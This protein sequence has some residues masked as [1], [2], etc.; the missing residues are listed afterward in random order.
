M[1]TMKTFLLFKRCYWISLLLVSG[2]TTPKVFSQSV[3]ELVFK[4]SYL[5]SGSAGQDGAKY[6]F[7]NVKTGIDAVLTIAGRSEAAVKLDQLDET[8]TGYDNAFQ[9]RIGRSGSVPANSSWWMEFEITFYMA[10]YTTAPYKVQI[11]NFKTTG[12]DIDGDNSGLREFTQ[13]NEITSFAT[14]SSSALQATLIATLPVNLYSNLPEFTYKFLAPTTGYPGIDT[15]AVSVM[16]TSQYMYKKSITFRIGGQTGGASVS[17]PSRQNSVWF[18][19]FSLSTL[20]VKLA[21]FTA[22]LKN[23]NAELKWTTSSEINVSHFV[24]ERSTDGENFSDAGMIFAYGNATDNTN[25]SFSDNVSSVQSGII[26]YRIR[27]VDI[28]GKSQ[29]SETRIIRISKTTD[30]N[31]T[32]QAYPNP[33][34]N[35]LRVSIPSSWQNKKVV[36]E[37]FSANGQAAKKMETASSNQTETLSVN[38]LAPGFYIVRVSCNGEIAQQKIIK[39]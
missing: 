36:Y 28:D 31:I 11:D 12:L 6:V 14:S 33:V 29:Y 8:G 37:L 27:S 3:Q 7:P 26:Y 5:L 34:I 9:P 38:S 13:M 25:Y 20:P 32:I 35:E 15:T 21:S 19:E 22:T 4:N 10:G 23:T 39:Q 18:K 24:V 16:V 17:S 1:K 30:S 2:I